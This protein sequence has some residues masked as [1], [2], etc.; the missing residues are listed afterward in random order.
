MPARFQQS[1]A[2]PPPTGNGRVIGFVSELG[3]LVVRRRDPFLA[4]TEVDEYGDL[5]LDAD[6][7]AETV[8]VVVHPVVHGEPLDR[9]GSGRRLERTGGQV[10]PGR[11]AGWLHLHKYAPV[12][13]STV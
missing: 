13:A 3:H 5:V 7:D 12:R 9:R 4:G 10:S 6:D 11:G 2:R 8:L 1:V